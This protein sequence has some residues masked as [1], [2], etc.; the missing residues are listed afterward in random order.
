MFVFIYKW[1]KKWR[2][3]HPW[4]VEARRLG[5]DSG[6]TYGQKHSSSASS[7]ELLSRACRGKLMVTFF[8]GW[9]CDLHN[10]RPKTAETSAIRVS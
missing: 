6:I 4:K 5:G 10:N 7:S 2:F 3:S 8:H 9:Y 1:L